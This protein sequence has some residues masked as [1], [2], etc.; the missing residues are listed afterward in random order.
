M[1]HFEFL[2]MFVWKHKCGIV[3]MCLEVCECFSVSFSGWMFG[4]LHLLSNPRARP[5]AGPPLCSLTVTGTSV[6]W[7]IGG[8]VQG[9]MLGGC[10]L[11][12]GG[13]W[14]S[15]DL[16][17]LWRLCFLGDAPRASGLWAHNWNW[18]WLA[19]SG[20]CGLLRALH[21]SL[22]TLAPGLSSVLLGWVQPF[23]CLLHCGVPLDI[24]GSGLL[25]VGLVP[26]TPTIEH[27]LI[28]NKSNKQSHSCIYT[29]AL[30]F[31]ASQ[32]HIYV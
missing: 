15:R 6:Y 23:L 5:L 14:T 8:C 13:Y 17:S 2:H 19:A 10:H 28:L 25:C 4:Y 3:W 24:W 32:I 27:I 29:T 11:I 31:K 20:A 12:P 30:W 26:L 16:V 22:W 18:A 21:H 9:L 1:C 7:V